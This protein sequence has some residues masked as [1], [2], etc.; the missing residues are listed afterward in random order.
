MINIGLGNYSS[1]HPII[2]SQSL[3]TLHAPCGSINGSHSFNFP[4]L[5]ALYLEHPIFNDP[6]CEFSELFSGCP[7]LKDL[8][9]HNCE[10]GLDAISIV[11]KYLEKLDI[12]V[13]LCPI[14]FKIVIEGPKLYALKYK[15]DAFVRILA[16]V[17]SME[18][19][20]LNCFVRHDGKWQK[21]GFECYS[22]A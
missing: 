19:V 13:Q 4:I 15:G 8:T 17:P 2:T 16:N 18:K 6:D 20:D 5:T 12:S 1:M 11:G 14:D 10:S 9:L 21:K 7:N 3:K 22:D